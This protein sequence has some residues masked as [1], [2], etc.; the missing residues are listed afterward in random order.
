MRLRDLQVVLD[1]SPHN[2]ARLAVAL[3]LA[4]ANEAHLTGLCPLELLFPADLGFALGGYPE[5]LALQAAVEE[6]Q[7]KAS[8]QAAAMEV[9]FR[10]ALRRQGVNGDWRVVAG[11]VGAAV[12][13]ASRHA[14][15]TVIG[16]ADPAHRGPPTGRHMVEDVLLGAGRPLLILPFAGSFPVIGRNVLIAWTETREAARAVGDALGL[17]DRDATVTVLTVARP[18]GLSSG[19][20]ETEVP[21]AE[22][23]AHLAR[24]GLAVTAA[25]TVG[26]GTIHEADMLLSYAADMGADLLV[27]GGYG[28]SRVRELTLGGVTRSVLRHMTVPVLM[29]H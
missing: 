14:D 20:A 23:A 18:S 7:S 13:G 26:D 5:V 15:L 25:R 12:V 10:E 8:A 6:L 28:H 1:A 21:G 24:H 9:E 3:D 11:P 22:I 29:S 19:R 2:A 16:Q 4:R 27:M 17:I